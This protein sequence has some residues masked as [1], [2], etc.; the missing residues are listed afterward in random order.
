MKYIEESTRL[1]TLNTLRVNT[2]AGGTQTTFL[3]GFK[4]LDMKVIISYI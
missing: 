1:K 4:Y 3:L 2:A